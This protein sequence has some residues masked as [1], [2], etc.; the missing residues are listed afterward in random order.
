MPLYVFKY[1]YPLLSRWAVQIVASSLRADPINGGKNCFRVSVDRYP[2]RILIALY[3]VSHSVII[4]DAERIALG[5][6]VRDTTPS[7]I[8]V[9]TTRPEIDIDVVDFRRLKVLFH[10]MG[11][12][13]KAK[14]YGVNSAVIIYSVL[15]APTTAPLPAA[16]RLP[17]PRIPS[18]LL[19]KNAEKRCM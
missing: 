12:D 3:L 6:H 2:Y 11:S 1:F 8:G 14:P 19:R 9:P 15:D 7:T 5:L 4:T 16:C 17:A 18:N 10:D 13:N